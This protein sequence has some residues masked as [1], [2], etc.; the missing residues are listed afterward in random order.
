MMQPIRGFKDILPSEIEWWQKIYIKSLELFRLF[1][2]QEIRT[3]ILEYN[4]L[5][6][7]EKEALSN[8]L[9]KEMYSFYDK[10][11]RYLSLRPEGTA[12]IMRAYL[13][14]KLYLNNYLQKLWYF[15]PMFR[16][17]RPQLGR[18]RQFYQLGLECIGSLNPASDVEIIR[19]ITLLFD[20]FYVKGYTLEINSIG[21]ILERSLY[22]KKLKEYLDPYLLDFSVEEKKKFKFNPLKLLD[23][24]NQKI[25]AILA[26]GPSIMHFLEEKSLKHFYT[27]CNN[28]NCLGISFKITSNL[29]RGLD[30]Y[31]YTAFEIKRS[32]QYKKQTLAGGGRYDSLC[33]TLGGPFV[34][35]VGGAIGLERFLLATEQDKTNSLYQRD[36]KILILTKDV[37]SAKYIWFIVTFLIENNISFEL[38]SSSHKLKDKILRAN[39]MGIKICLIINTKDIDNSCILLKNLDLHLNKLIKI[40]DLIKYLKY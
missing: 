26:E 28:L 33:S 10:N 36:Q 12:S 11:Q 14:N 38:D 21:N 25:Q 20:F 3:P 15:S 35:A 6:L 39:N 13:S 17:E 22:I 34:P 24:K 19:L 29:V 40:Q 27:V 4:A 18:Q 9:S 7:R 23:T 31:N 1:N 16:Y 5:F 8:P 30:Y 32:C 37:S 2:Y